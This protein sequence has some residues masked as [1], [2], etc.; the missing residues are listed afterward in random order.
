MSFFEQLQ[1]RLDEQHSWPGPYL[2]K[3]VVPEPQRQNLLGLMPTGLLEERW[4]K[5]GRYVSLSLK[6]QMPHSQAVIEVYK[7]VQGV[8]G[9][10]S[11]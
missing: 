7:R 11:L 2:F 5:N 3:F 9:L 8:E 4:S 6:T 10:I 1:A